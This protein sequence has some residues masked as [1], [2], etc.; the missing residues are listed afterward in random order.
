MIHS[1]FILDHE[2]FRCHIAPVLA[3]VDQGNLELLRVQA[4]AVIGKIEPKD[5]LL[6]EQG[7]I[8]ESLGSFEDIDHADVGYWLL[9]LMSTFLQRAPSLGTDWDV[10]LSALRIVG[11]S[12]DDSWLLVRGVPTVSL[13]KPDVY[14][15]PGTKL[16]ESDP[17]WHWMVP[18]QSYQRGWLPPDQVCDL[19]LR[20]ES[21]RDAIMGL[22]ET[23]IDSSYGRNPDGPLD[24]VARL[25]DAYGKALEMLGAARSVG[26]ALYMVIS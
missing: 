5:W 14:V 20:L 12:R 26:Q 15:A 10:L 17:Y 22:D 8:L 23:V 2:A 21:V 9:V 13:L 19:E 18:T 4:E 7:T 11:W 3:A 24:N 16:K 6:Q 25:R 1:A